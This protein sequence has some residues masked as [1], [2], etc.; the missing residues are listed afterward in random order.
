MNKG[1]IIPAH[2]GSQRIP[3]K[4]GIA[5][6]VHYMPVHLHPLYREQFHTYPGLWPEA[7]AVYE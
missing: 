3:R 4:K 1:A 6:N 2:G 5:V 7:E